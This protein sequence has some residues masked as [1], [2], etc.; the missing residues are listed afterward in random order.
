MNVAVLGL[1]HLG[2]VTAACMAAAGH[3]VT[4]FDPNPATVE[5]LAGG[6]P[7]VAE[8][9]LPELITRGLQAGNLRFT[10]ALPMAIRTAEVVWV[11][12]DTPVDEEDR[13]D[14]GYVE[15]HVQAVFPHLADHAVVVLSSQLPV[16]TV[17]KLEQ[18][19][20]NVADGRTVSFASAPENLRLGNAIEVFTMPDRI[21][22]GVRDEQ[23]RQR[24][25]ALLS[26]IGARIEWMSIE[27]AEMTKHAVNAFLATSVTFANELAAI[28]ERAG[29][30][31]KE[32][33]RGL[34]TER[35][36]GPYAY[37]SPGGAFAG[38]TLARDVAFLRALGNELG[39]PTPLMDGVVA[40]NAQHNLWARRRLETDI[41]S[42]AGRK[43][44][45][46][47]LTYK[48]GTDTI[49]RS[50]AIELCR[51]LVGQGARVHVHD[52][53]ATGLPDDLPV[54]RHQ[55]PLDAVT[56]AQALVVATDW[57]LYRDI[58]IE[59]LATVAPDLLV[60]DANRFLGS[61]LG[62]DARFRVVAVGQP[63]V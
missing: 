32:V 9:G 26:P 31:A 18:A 59:R 23:A 5:A 1:W 63:Q 16:G 3:S 58:D 2:S 14:R 7:P 33:E 39:Q 50:S 35:R 20:S 60:L 24:M 4:G 27:S 54:T 34:R 57:P 28:C 13:A 22:V 51:W 47:G 19:W 8:P 6:R 15:K 41:G 56:E 62:S 12:F 43:V 40:S 61:T 11:A 53:A 36:I 55:D 29:A 49:R 45:I 30:D 37:L 42:L 44:A 10:T 21:V 52:P 25:A 46:W 48:P 17:R 38:G